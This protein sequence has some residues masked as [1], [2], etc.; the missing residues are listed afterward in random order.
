[1]M[2]ALG[3]MRAQALGMTVVA[4]VLWMMSDRVSQQ[5]K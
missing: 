2:Q 5:L 1:M 4:V 3:M